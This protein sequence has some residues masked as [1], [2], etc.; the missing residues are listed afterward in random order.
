M[1][2]PQKRRGP[3]DEAEL[4]LLTAR[5]RALKRTQSN[6]Q[7]TDWSDP[8]WRVFLLVLD[9]QNTEPSI[10]KSRDHYQKAFPDGL[11]LANLAQLVEGFPDNREGNLALARSI[12][13][14]NHGP[15]ASEL[16]GFLAFLGRLNVG[17]YAGLR[18]W[19]VNASFLDFENK[20]PGLD[21][22]MF[23]YL[24]LMHGV[25]TLK[26]DVH[27]LRFVETAIGRKLSPHNTVAALEEVA[28]RIE[29]SAQEL[30]ASI[31][32]ARKRGAG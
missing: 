21:I 14:N 10:K 1:I 29:W 32:E 6:Y 12:W 30:D 4:D 3:A 15:R 8:T 17:D 19:A 11:T 18:A 20:V 31:W 9:K 5:C 13:G 7:A 25:D 22:G 16:R 26:P 24:Q 23:K 2:R 28:R 27:I